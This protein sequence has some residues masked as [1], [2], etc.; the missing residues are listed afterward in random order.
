MDQA[1]PR[2]AIVGTPVAGNTRIELKKILG[3]RV[4]P[5]TQKFFEDRNF[6]KVFLFEFNE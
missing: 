2:D 1:T 4:A 5:I 3:T 6:S